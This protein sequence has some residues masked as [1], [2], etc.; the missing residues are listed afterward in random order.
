MNTMP[1]M[2][3]ELTTPKDQPHNNVLN[4]E[5]DKPVMSDSTDIKNKSNVIEFPYGNGE[6]YVITMNVFD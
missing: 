3:L 1:A 2:K 5:S 6:R 4:S